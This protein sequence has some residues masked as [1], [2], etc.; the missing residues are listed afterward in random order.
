MVAWLLIIENQNYRCQS[1]SLNLT[2][3]TI[4]VFVVFA[5]LTWWKIG[6]KERIEQ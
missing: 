4:L 6:A 3:R 1:L 2:A 5:G